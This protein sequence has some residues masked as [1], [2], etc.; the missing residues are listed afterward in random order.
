MEILLQ[1]IHRDSFTLRD[2]Q[3]EIDAHQSEL[4]ECYAEGLERDDEMSGRV[5]FHFRIAPDGH[6]ALIKVTHSELRDPDTEE[7]FVE[8]MAAWDFP[9]TSQ[10]ALIKF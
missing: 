6:V 4:I 2:I 1:K 5:D 8:T 7:C 9:A 10:Q 3:A